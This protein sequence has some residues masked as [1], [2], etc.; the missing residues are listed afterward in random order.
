MVMVTDW[1]GGEN[2]PESSET[3]LKYFHHMETV[4]NM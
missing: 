2:N 3:E 4:G 1:K